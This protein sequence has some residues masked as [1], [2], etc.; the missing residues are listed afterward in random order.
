[1][2]SLQGQRW[3]GPAL[4]LMAILGSTGLAR[5]EKAGLAEVRAGEG[6]S[7]EI[8]KRFEA[9]AL[10]GLQ[11][12]GHSV[13]GPDEVRSKLGGQARLAGCRGGD[14]IGPMSQALGVDTVVVGEVSAQEKNY[15]VTLRALRGQGATSSEVAKVEE[16]CD[17]CTVSEAAQAV[18]KAG[19]AMSER[20]TKLGP[21]AGATPSVIVTAPPEG[22]PLAATPPTP[23]VNP[24]PAAPPAAAP[25]QTSED[26]P[27]PWRKWVYISGAV[28]LVGLG[29]GI[30][31][32][33]VDGRPTC[34][35]P[36]PVHQCPEVLNTGSVGYAFTAVGA[37]GLVAAG[38][39]LY[40]DLRKPAATAPERTSS[41]DGNDDSILRRTRVGIT[42][43]PGGALL[44]G[45]YQF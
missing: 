20:L 10:K 29:V 9:A 30:P 43:R 21:P 28:G 23:P 38:V 33:V 7:P 12:G 25:T 5:A 37:V 39:F 14:C 6:V 35:A 8:R 11:T 24:A 2:Q 44:G 19:Q 1:M 15:V 27:R 13:L 36:D 45:S 22:N 40:L 16:R 26:R 42:P 31:L 41:S 18:E 32:A 3:L 4:A 17:I 34:S